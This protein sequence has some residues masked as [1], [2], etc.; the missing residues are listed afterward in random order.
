MAQPSRP[1]GVDVARLI[2]D[3]GISI[4]DSLHQEDPRFFD[5]L[6]LE[7]LLDERLAGKHLAYELRTR[8]KMSKSL[9][10][11]AA[12]F[13]GSEFGCLCSEVK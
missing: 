7:E 6:S 8:A 13:S 12:S 4:Y 10:A 3:S 2:H 5:I 11:D 1:D 9:V